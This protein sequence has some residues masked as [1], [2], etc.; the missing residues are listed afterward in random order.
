MGHPTN[1]VDTFGIFTSID[2]G[3]QNKVIDEGPHSGAVAT[4]HTKRK[5]LPR[6]FQV[7]KAQLSGDF[8][9]RTAPHIVGMGS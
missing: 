3:N 5:I 1:N 4:V 8:L 2:V 6:S 7:Q 9:R